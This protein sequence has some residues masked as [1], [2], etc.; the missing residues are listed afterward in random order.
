M[1]LRIIA[2]RIK[3]ITPEREQAFL[4]AVAPLLQ[5][6]EQA[7]IAQGTL[8]LVEES[9]CSVCGGPHYPKAAPGVGNADKFC[10]DACRERSKALSKNAYRRKQKA[11][12]E[13]N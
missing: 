9:Q 4:D 7:Q 10:S 11:G 12:T 3:K 13:G 8:V 1:Y 6:G 2:D 5:E